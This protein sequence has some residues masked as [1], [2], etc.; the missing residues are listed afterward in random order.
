MIMLYPGPTTPTTD[1]AASAWQQGL[2]VQY[3]YLVDARTRMGMKNVNWRNAILVFDEAHNVEVGEP[4]RLRLAHISRAQLEQLAL[5]HTRE[6]P[7]ME[8]C[9]CEPARTL[10]SMLHF[11][12]AYRVGNHQLISMCFSIVGGVRRRC[13]L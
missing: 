4:S 6:I 1:V 8:A 11:A 13:I 9:C 12:G 10:F 3:N 2:W 5:R 7:L